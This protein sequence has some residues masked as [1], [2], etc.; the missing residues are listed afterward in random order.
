M[1]SQKNRTKSSSTNKKSNKD[2]ATSA[3]LLIPIIDITQNTQEI[4][5]T[6]KK[7]HPQL[8]PPQ[9]LCWKLSNKEITTDLQKYINMTEKVKDRMLRWKYLIQLKIISDLSM[10]MLV[11]LCIKKLWKN[12]GRTTQF[13]SIEIRWIERYVRRYQDKSN[14]TLPNRTNLT[15]L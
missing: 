3:V 4:H 2:E 10:K 14:R 13:T 9:I 12:I 5:Q 15:A 6:S 8:H 7:I 11:L 1:K